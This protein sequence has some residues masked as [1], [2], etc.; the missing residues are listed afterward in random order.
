MT[1][2]HNSTAHI[3]KNPINR[4]KLENYLMDETALIN[5]GFRSLYIIY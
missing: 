3:K 5:F 2:A 1:K 4:R